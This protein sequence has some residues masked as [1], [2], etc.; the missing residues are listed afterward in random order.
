MA[1]HDFIGLLTAL[2]VVDNEARRTAEQ[3]LEEAKTANPE[4]LA[5]A[6]I[7]TCNETDAATCPPHVR[8]LAAVLLRGLV[9]G[10]RSEWSRMSIGVRETIKDALLHSVN[11]GEDFHA[12]LLAIV[13]S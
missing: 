10:S 1:S 12:L 4:E 13:W 11:H 6:L 5:A 8:S 9:A 2:C 3:T 7:K